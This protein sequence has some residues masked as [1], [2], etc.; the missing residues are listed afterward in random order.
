MVNNCHS[1]S[2]KIDVQLLR[3]ELISLHCDFGV[4][5]SRILFFKSFTAHYLDMSIDFRISRHSMFLDRKLGL[6]D[7]EQLQ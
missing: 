1:I 3:Q 6:I 7:T 2:E 5:W 4:K